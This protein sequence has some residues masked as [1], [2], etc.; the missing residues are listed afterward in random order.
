MRRKL[1]M[2]SQ[3]SGVGF[4]RYN[5]CAIKIIPFPFVAVV[6]GA[7]VARRPVQQPRLRVISSREPRGRTPV[8]DRPASPGFRTGSTGSGH[9]P[10]APDTFPG[11]GTISIQKSTN[12]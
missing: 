3:F 8:F 7:G 5:G 2:P 11:R 10:E 4:E 1:V 6:I 9:G 12:P